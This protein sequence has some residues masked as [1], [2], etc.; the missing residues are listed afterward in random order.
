MLVSHAVIL[1]IL[2]H[3]IIVTLAVVQ[4]EVLCAG[5]LVNGSIQMMLRYHFK[6]SRDTIDVI[7]FYQCALLSHCINVIT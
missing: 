4:S 2:S 1:S 7:T 3:G 5:A 6:Y